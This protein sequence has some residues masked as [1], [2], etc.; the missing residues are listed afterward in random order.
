MSQSVE[1]Q[2]VIPTDPAELA[3]CLADPMWRLSHLYKILIKGDE[4]QEDTVMHFRP[5]RAQRRFMERLWYRNIILKARQLGFTTLI[6]ILWLD[7]ALFRE[8]QRCGIVAHNRDAAATIFRDKVKFG[9]ESMP[10]AI[11]QMIPAIEWNADEVRFSNN[12]AIQVA[13]SLRS[14]T[15]HRV[16]IS[17][18]GKIC[19]LY[20]QKA[21]EVQTGTLPAVPLHGIAVIESTAEGMDGDFYKKTEIAQAAHD[22]GKMLGIKDWRFHFFPWWQEPKY[23]VDPSTVVINAEHEEYFEVT[24][25][26]VGHTFDLMQR[27]WYVATLEGDFSGDE[28]IMWREYPSFPQ[29]AFKVS[30]LGVY[31]AKELARA[32]REGR[33]GI[34]PHMPGYPVNTFWD[35]GLNDVTS[36]WFHQRINGL[37]RFIRYYENEG[38]GPAHFVAYM[39]QQTGYVYGRHYL[40]HDGNTRHMTIDKPMTYK[41]MLGDLHVYNVEIVKRVLHITTG[42]QA[43]RQAFPGCCFDEKNCAVGLKHVQNYRKQWNNT[44]VCWSDHP[45]HDQASNAADALRQFAQGYKG[46]VGTRTARKPSDWKTG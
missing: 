13:T 31:Y 6:C 39:Q 35:I 14:G 18:Y 8:N 19:A 30:T 37:D 28:E 24:E 17:E 10:E 7:H 4:G 22:A 11:R 21:V 26:Q 2:P 15:Y 38:E 46:N 42:I 32:R 9:Y 43:M 27:A 20:P 25:A 12:S 33:I 16:L 29:E 41:D 23:R 36:L 1:D 40:P 34:Y 5:N 3:K 45:K 44:L